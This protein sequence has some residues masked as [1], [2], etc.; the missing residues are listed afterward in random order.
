MLRFK[1]LAMFERRELLVFLFNDLKQGRG[2]AQADRQITVADRGRH[3]EHP[4]VTAVLRSVFYVSANWPTLLE[5]A[6]KQPENGA[7]RPRMAHDLVRST[8]KFIPAID[9]DALEDAVSGLN[10]AS[11]VSA[12]EK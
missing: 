5:F 6:P 12:R 11:G 7:R 10:N 1:V 4:I 8:H 3:G 9:A 2:W